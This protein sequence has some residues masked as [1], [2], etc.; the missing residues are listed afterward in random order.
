MEKYLN[1]LVFVVGFTATLGISFLYYTKLKS[2]QLLNYIPNIWTSLGILGTFIAIVCA[3][4][5][6]PIS[7]E[8]TIVISSLI[9]SIAPAFITSI[10][11]IVGAIV[12]SVAIK[13]IYA[14]EEKREE[15]FYDLVAGS[16]NSP[17]LLLYKIYQAIHVLINSTKQQEANIKVFLDDYMLQLGTFYDQIYEVNKQQVKILS[18]EYVQQVSE[19]LRIVNSEINNRMDSLLLTH[20]TSIQDYLK[21]EKEGLE[22]IT[23]SIQSFINALPEHINDMTTEMIDTLRN[24]I[25]E[26]YN[27]LLEGNDAFINQLINRVKILESELAATSTQT[28]SDTIDASRAEIQKIITLLEQTLQSQAISIENTSMVLSNNMDSLNESLN[29]SV[30]DYNGLVEQLNKLIPILQNQVRLS[31]SNTDLAEKNSVQMSEVLNT[32]DEIVKKNQQLRY[33]LTQWKRV[34]KKV[35]VND[36]NN[37]KEC[38]NCAT[39]NPIDANFCRKCNYGFWDCETIASS[40]R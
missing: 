16:N 23:N 35:K 4:D 6:L 10:I 40:I 5:D 3:L 15:K 36:K 20:S 24:A 7:A 11:G 25:V 19:V 29:K 22:N 2:R 32:L 39:E 33:E 27:H 38:P 9:S 18:D 8:G 37:T 21:L 1:L 14:L 30:M 26:K 34:H 12:T 13:V 31:E 17:E 28:C